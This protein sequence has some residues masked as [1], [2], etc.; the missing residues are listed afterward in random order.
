MNIGFLMSF[1]TR[2]F[3]LQN[4]TSSLEQQIIITYAGIW[5]L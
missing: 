5:Y 1:L 3:Y 2:L 4:D